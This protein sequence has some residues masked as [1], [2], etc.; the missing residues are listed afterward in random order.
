MISPEVVRNYKRRQKERQTVSLSTIM[1][2]AR[3]GASI[4]VEIGGFV[5]YL[6]DLLA[7]Q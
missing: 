3:I 2:D 1:L 7:E 4:V 6:P 5:K